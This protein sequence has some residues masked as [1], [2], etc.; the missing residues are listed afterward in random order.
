[1][2]QSKVSRVEAS[3]YL[4]ALNSGDLSLVDELTRGCYLVRID[5]FWLAC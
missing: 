5:V 2:G 1:M 4:R 3:S